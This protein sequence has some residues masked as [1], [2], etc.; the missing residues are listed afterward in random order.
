MASNS[1][2]AVDPD[3]PEA[4]PDWIE[5]YNP[6]EVTLDLEGFTI[7]DDLADP[8]KHVLPSFVLEPGAFVVLIADGGT[9]GLHLPFKLSAEGE[10]I[11]IFDPSGVPLDQVEY[12]DLGES[13][14]AGRLPDGGELFILSPASPGE[15]NSAA[16]AVDP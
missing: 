7:T 2:V 6:S 12:D 8:T 3:D 14:V 13:Q 16:Q 9:D 4:T 10:Q 15:S 1:E 11:G 5:L